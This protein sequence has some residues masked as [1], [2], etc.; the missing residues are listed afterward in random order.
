MGPLVAHAAATGGVMLFC[1][2]YTCTHSAHMVNYC[3]DKPVML[4]SCGRVLEAE[5]MKWQDDDYAETSIYSY[6]ET[7]AH[8][9]QALV[10]K[11]ESTKYVGMHAANLWVYLAR[12]LQITNMRAGDAWF[13]RD[14]RDQVGGSTRA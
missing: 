12:G 14:G 2:E 4:R 8:A 9:E 3:K 11:S 10:R 6:E 5:T 7:V 13:P 1:G